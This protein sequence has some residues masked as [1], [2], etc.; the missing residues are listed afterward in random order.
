MSEESYHG[1]GDHGNSKMISRK[2]QPADIDSLVEHVL[3]N[4]A[5]RHRD[6]LKRSGWKC[7]AP[8]KRAK[9]G[10]TRRAWNRAGRMELYLCPAIA[11][12]LRELN[13]MEGN[14]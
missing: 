8:P 14:G 7:K 9:N 2:L 10:I 1:Y 12:R 3:T 6:S 4:D 5:Q 11:E 13:Q